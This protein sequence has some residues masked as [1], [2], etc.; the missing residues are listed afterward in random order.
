MLAPHAKFDSSRREVSELVGGDVG[1]ESRKAY[2]ETTEED[3][4]K[5]GNDNVE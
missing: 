5:Y 2:G 4:E 3:A 1:Y